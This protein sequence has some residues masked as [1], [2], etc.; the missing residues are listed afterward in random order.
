[1]KLV[2]VWNK[3][4]WTDVG[5]YHTWWE[6]S[7]GYTYTKGAMTEVSTDS[8][9]DGKIWKIGFGGH[10]GTVYDNQAASS[11]GLAG[12]P[13]KAN[14]IQITMKYREQDRYDYPCSAN[15]ETCSPD[16]H[17]AD[18]FWIVQRGLYNPG[19][20]WQYIRSGPSVLKLD[21]MHGWRCCAQKKYW[22]GFPPGSNHNNSQGQGITY[23][24]GASISLGPITV[25]IETETGNSTESEQSIAF[26]DSTKKRYN[27]IRHMRTDEHELWGNDAP[28]SSYP[29]VF[30]NY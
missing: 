14:V 29:N 30:Y 16:V 12:G 8:S 19:H 26:S 20:G 25:E 5:E 1:M 3:H 21:G 2:T 24:K 7:G 4:E 15:N 6:A 17:C 18:H 11:D 28:V 10:E 22:N 13:F 27:E 9:V 23:E